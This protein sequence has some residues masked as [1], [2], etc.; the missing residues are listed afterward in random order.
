MTEAPH[1]SLENDGSAIH[2]EARPHL[3]ALDLGSNSFHLIVARADGP[4]L[5][6]LERLR[7]PVRLAAGLDGDGLLDDASRTRA[8]NALGR[9]G[10]LLRGYP[11]VRLRAVGTN[12]FRRARNADG[13][14]EKAEALLGHEIEIL[15][16]VEEAR[17]IFAGVAHM[18]PGAE[19][20]LVLDVGGGSTECVVGRGTQVLRAH[21]SFMGCVSYT[22]RFFPDGVLDADSFRRAEIA[23]KVEIESVVAPLRSSGWARVLGASGTMRALHRVLKVA[24]FDEEPIRLVGLRQLEGAFLRAK[25]LDA[26]EL[27]SIKATRRA[28]LPGGFAI[29]KALMEMFEIERI[30]PAQGALR[31]GVLWDLDARLQHNDIRDRTMERL[32]AVYG[33]EIAQAERVGATSE[34][35]RAQIPPAHFHD[36]ARAA[37]LLQ[38]AAAVHEIGLAVS[39]SGSHKHA[40]YLLEHGDLPGFSADDQRRLARLVRLH[41]RKLPPELIPRADESHFEDLRGLI[42]LLRLAVLLHRSRSTTPV[43]PKLAVVARSP[44]EATDW[45]ELRLAI[46]AEY[47]DKHPLCV[48]ELEDEVKLLRRGLGIELTL[49]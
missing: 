32:Q 36:P 6:V 48:R 42:A 20:R 8:L 18:Q 1:G 29:V 27:P 30:E 38:W 31:E 9:I 11:G 25:Q 46:P 10:E 7:E 34:K 44:H 47:A 15:S 35:L 14:R 23:A 19:Q 13:F 5:H 16:G 28:V 45:T 3:A 24:G 2:D 49:Q 33:I 12:A 39:Y 22:E 37:Q 41:R 43:D 21:S 17:L 26:L 40:A 4:G